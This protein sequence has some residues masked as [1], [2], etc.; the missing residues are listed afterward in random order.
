M[1]KDIRYALRQFIKNPGFAIVAVLTL[2]LGIGATAAM[3]GLIK[4][5]LM[6]PPPYAEPNRL[7]LISA[8]RTDGAPYNQRPTTAHW[9]AWRDS[10]K[11]IESVAL[12]GWTFN[13][14]VRPDGSESL[15]GMVVNRD[16][17]R[18]LGLKPI[19]GREFID[20]EAGG[21]G[22]PPT[23]VI[24]GHDLWRRQFNGDPQ[25]VG[26]TLQLSRM[27][28]PLPI[29]GVMPAGARFLPDPAAAAEPNYD[30]DAQVDFWLLSRPNESQPRSR[31]WN[32]LAR[33][34]PGV[35]AA[36]ANTEIAA[37]ATGITKTDAALEGLTATTRP[38]LDVTNDVGK[39]L[40]LPLFG[41]VGLV[42]FIACANVAGLLLARGLQRQ[43]EYALRA[44]LGA[45]WRR[46]ARQALTESVALASIAAVVGGVFA[47]G[48][49]MLFTTIGGQALPRADAVSVG[50]P[51]FAFCLV[52]AF[53]AA[54]VSGL[55][56]A[57]RAALRT[58]F[59]GLESTRST[60]SRGERRLVGAVAVLQI[61]L[62]VALLSGA[63]L[64][65]RTAQNLARVRPG[66]D[67]ENILALTVTAVQGDQWKAFHTQALERVAAIPGVRHAAFAWGLP[68]TGNNWP[69]D[70]EVIGATSSERLAERLTVPLRAVTPD[71]FAAMGIALVEGRAFRMTDDA[72]APRVAIVNQSFVQRH[73]G[74][75]SALGRTIRSFGNAKQSIEIVG[76]VSDTRTDELTGTSE[77]EVYFPLWQ[78]RAFS[79]HLVVRTT[80]DPVSV[81][82]LVR[83]EI[84]VVDPT[85]AVEHVKTMAEIRRE[86][87]APRTFAM[88]VLIGFSV[89]A[90][91]LALV[92]LY[93]VLSLSVG[94][95]TKEIAVR[96]AVG[97]EWHG[98]VR[99]VLGEGFRLVGL[100][101]V[102]GA[103]LAIGVGRVLSS[104]LF[105]V[106][107]ADPIMLG[108]AALVFAAFAVMACA[109]PAWRATRVDLMEAL[110]RE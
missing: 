71:Y 75:S 94:S 97:A 40:L 79:K 90:M 51:V 98:I 63:A 37:I 52:A 34:R 88:H 48:M 13:F 7:V 42:F 86:S 64:L 14:L 55:L 1:V 82:P 68:L 5:V 43:S 108:G 56:P 15:G 17:F 95:R 81:A 3:F 69:G 30:V 77:P 60:A 107:P 24:I 83:R 12:Y 104:L 33:L 109:M 67:T 58:R 31:G 28:A 96:K 59:H 46:L 6:S 27:P 23:A 22:V 19:L 105:G 10:A 35:T 66:Y 70:M 38:L 102:F 16:Y 2:G 18:V 74:G 20:S 54:L 103:G 11:S 87:E 65:V 106:Q 101:V 4:G 53:L 57:A 39:R 26:K 44:A 76:V 50:W 61:V 62:T 80:G 29:V 47:A 45:T 49:V 93:G 100:G 25:M 36:A 89:A 85:A 78:S 73:L 91:V 9:V 92:G 8:A 21:G 32:V 41:A 99:M 110:R 72:E 84:A